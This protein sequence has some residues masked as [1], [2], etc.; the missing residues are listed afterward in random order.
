M[1]QFL[2]ESSSAYTKHFSD[3]LEAT[4]KRCNKGVGDLT[5][6]VIIFQETVNTNVL[7]SSGRRSDSSVTFKN[8]DLWKLLLLL[9]KCNLE[10]NWPT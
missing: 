10:N 2:C 4:A 8:F 5:P 6:A 7:G 1:Y 3:E 9:K